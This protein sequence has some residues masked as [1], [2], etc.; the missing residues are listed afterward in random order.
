MLAQS[1]RDWEHI[2]VDGGSTD[3]TLD[4]LRKY[5][6]LH[7]SSSPDK[8]QSDAMNKAFAQSTGDLII[9]LNADDELKPDALRLF[10]DSFNSHPEADMVVADLEINHS[11]TANI[12]VPSINLRQVLNYWPCIF[13]ANPVSYAY[14]RKLQ[15]NIGK[16]P[17]HNHYTMDYWFLLRAFLKGKVV[18]EGFVAGTF[19]F[20]GTNKSAD[21]ANSQKWLKR[22][23]D[24]FLSRYFYYP[25]V[26]KFWIRLKKGFMFRLK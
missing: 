7:W 8:G 21:P 23:R 15:D 17:V 25:E 14:K 2:I 6:H 19:H 11:G 26:A 3:A 22:V 4:V 12:N 10:A 18:K 20:D 5:P 16:F 9:Y 1:Y 24:Q 13:P